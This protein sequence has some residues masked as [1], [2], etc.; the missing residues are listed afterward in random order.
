VVVAG[1]RGYAAVGQRLYVLDASAPTAA[2]VLGRSEL[3]GGLIQSLTVQGNL[4]Y[5]S[6]GP[7]GMTTLDV[8]DAS[9]PH[10]V[11]HVDGQVAEVFIDGER[12]YLVEGT[13]GV[14][15]VE[16]ANPGHELSKLPG[17][18]FI[19]HAVASGNYLF[20]V[21][22][23]LV[24]WDITNLAAPNDLRQL[25]D[26]ADGVAL[27]GTTLYAATSEEAGPGQRRGYV[28]AW[29]LT[30]PRRPVAQGKVPA[31]GQ[32]RWFGLQ[33]DE[34]W[35]LSAER[36]ERFD[37]TDPVGLP[38]LG[39]APALAES[40]WANRAGN[41]AWLAAGARGLRTIPVAGAGPEGTRLLDVPGRPESLAQAD[42]RLYVEDAEE[43]ILIFD[44][45]NPTNGALGALAGAAESGALTAAD[46]YLYIGTAD[47]RLRIVDVHDAAA[48]R[49]VA[50]M[51]L[52]YLVTRIAVA[53]GYAYLATDPELRVVDVRNP[54]APQTIS[55]TRPDGGITEMALGG[56]WLYAVGPNTGPRPLPSLKVIDVGSPSTPR[57][58][59][60]TEAKDAVAGMA[61]A[62]ELVF[63]ATLQVVDACRPDRPVQVARLGS[64]GRTRT[65][66]ADAWRVYT[67][68]RGVVGGGSL[69][70]FDV[71]VPSQP[72]EVAQLVTADSMDGVAA[73]GGR[74]WASAREAGL[75][76]GSSPEVYHPTPTP[77]LRPTATR[78]PDLRSG[79]FLPYTL[80]APPARP[81]AP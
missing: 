10:A 30:N 53:G 41:Q 48:P 64:T 34:I 28:Q 18:E 38:K 58:R 15:L 22:R 13:S 16:T 45:A 59:G 5:A 65:V 12:M 44:A 29:D 62:D 50:E 32:A 72:V 23:N 7:A 26:W 24:N 47:R 40:I 6:L 39:E 60:F 46:G 68:R 61:T 17:V 56:R 75:L 4:V 8:A 31:A 69:S 9:R 63:V 11:G 49:Q 36:L 66:A 79:A 51:T 81:C 76:W 2:P 52:P 33:G 80:S 3:L 74:F 37:A 27:R 21:A 71:H 57:L 43:R 14:R 70:F 42:G 54:A 1:N 55:V 19:N 20:T 77:D 78:P 25:A 35:M 73:Q 67:A